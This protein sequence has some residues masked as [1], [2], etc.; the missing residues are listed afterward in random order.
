[1]V[2]SG[3]GWVPGSI[4]RIP[5]KGGLLILEDMKEKAEEELSSLRKEE[6]TQKNN[7]QA[8]FAACRT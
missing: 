6:M 2:V 8:A 1:M 5:E 4:T 7:F 3:A